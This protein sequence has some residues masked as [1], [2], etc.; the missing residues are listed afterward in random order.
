MPDEGYIKYRCLH[1]HADPPPMEILAELN[2]L[3]TDLFRTG[4]IGV[5]ESGVGYGNVSMRW[6]G[7]TFW[8]TASR[9]GHVPRLGAEGYSL[10]ERCDIVGNIVWSRGSMEASSEAMTHAAVYA[11]S[12][13]AQCVVHAHH[14]AFFH[15]LLQG[16]APATNPSAAFGTP[17]MALSVSELVRLH[18]ADGVIAMT[19]HEDGI[20]LYAPDM[21]HMRDLLAMLA[22]GYIPL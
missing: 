11:A 3:R 17:G 4:F 19:G 10:V 8:I 7:G 2:D 9:T 15:M 12:P 22:Q 14:H 13:V 5:T 6:H 1:R 21:G 20:I 18:P 16:G